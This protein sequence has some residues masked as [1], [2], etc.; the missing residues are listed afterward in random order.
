[1][2]LE[3]P[4]RYLELAPVIISAPTPRCGTTLAQ[5]LI[6]ESDNA[7]IYGEEIGNQIRPL[8][9]VL[10]GL[11]QHFE[12]AGDAND[13]DFEKALAGAQTD[14]RPGLLPP[15]QVML[16]A[17]VETFYQL[18]MAL[19]EFGRS[20]GRPVWGFKKPDFTRDQLRAFL[21]LMPKARVIYIFRRLDD[22]LRS[23]KARRF[24]SDDASI[25]AFCAAWAKNLS[26]VM[27]LGSDQRILFVRYEEFVEARAAHI[28]AFETFTGALGLKAEA[29]E[30]KVNTFAGDAANGHSPT[31]Y[32]APAEL[33]DADRA[34]IETSAGP[35]MAE[36]YPAAAVAPSH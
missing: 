32:I 21:M 4:N 26:E 13:A 31:Q 5:R 19:A 16:R 15:T 8:A 36:L 3:V 29:F 28:R 22:V 18:P 24:V 11:I 27:S 20:I 35:L 12:R 23:A 6:S 9:N 34:A 25:A 2:P 1:L 14:W 30:T 10:L 7:F 33:T 17:W